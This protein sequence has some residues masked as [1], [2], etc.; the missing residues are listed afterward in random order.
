MG[1]T[2]DD[3]FKDRG[4]AQ[5]ARPQR[6]LFHFK[7]LVHFWASHGGEVPHACGRAAR[8]LSH[9]QALGREWL[10]ELHAAS[11]WCLEPV[12]E[13]LRLQ[14][15]H[16]ALFVRG[17]VEQIHQGVFV[18]IDGQHGEAVHGLTTGR[19]PLV[20]EPGNSHGL[21]VGS[22]D[23]GGNGFAGAPVWL[24]DG[25]GRDDA[26]ACL[27]PRIPKTRFD[28][29]RLGAGVVRVAAQLEGI[30]PVGHQAVLPDQGFMGR[31]G[32]IAHVGMRVPAD[33]AA[34]V[35][36]PHVLLAFHSGG[37]CLEDLPVRL[38]SLDALVVAT[39]AVRPVVVGC[40]VVP[41]P[42]GQ[43]CG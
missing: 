21:V 10:Q 2:G 3:Q 42:W 12:V 29:H 17:L 16:H 20:P 28:G 23:A 14:D 22:A 31:Y 1:C 37:L 30:S 32:F 4:Q 41:N 36:G 39:H 13:L 40:L 34:Q 25:H 24:V 11:H 26:V 27:T 18:R 9:P 38:G 19:F 15:Y 43:C 7:R 8:A 33:K 6:G 5:H 35:A